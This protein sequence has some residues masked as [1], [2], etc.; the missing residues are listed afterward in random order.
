MQPPKSDQGLAADRT[1]ISVTISA[2]RSIKP[3]RAIVSKAGWRSPPI[4]SVQLD[5]GLTRLDFAPIRLAI[6]ASRPQAIQVAGLRR[7]LVIDIHSR[8]YG[9]PDHRLL[10]SDKID[11][12]RGADQQL[13]G[14][15][16]IVRIEDVYNGSE[17]I[18]VTQRKRAFK[19]YR[20]SAKLSIACP[21]IPPSRQT[22]PPRPA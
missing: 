4:G 22:S 17:S 11:L 20:L 18:P 16:D 21:L 19:V 9:G 12:D 2:W 15:D 1:R 7:R 14:E 3:R 5:C 13:L 6:L 10:N 8:A